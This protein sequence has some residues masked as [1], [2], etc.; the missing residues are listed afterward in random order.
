MSDV[1]WAL[2]DAMSDE[3]R[4]RRRRSSKNRPSK[5][6]ISEKK[7]ELAPETT[8]DNEGSVTNDDIPF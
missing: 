2:R 1:V 5:K 6:H 8:S 3:V 4:D 7:P